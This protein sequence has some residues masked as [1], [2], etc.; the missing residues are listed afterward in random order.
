MTNFV[1]TVTYRR[2]DAGDW[3]RN[4]LI[5]HLNS[6]D[7]NTFDFWKL[8]K[9]KGFTILVVKKEVSHDIESVNE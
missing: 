4:V 6:E 9:D 7:R 1:E 5:E 3:A 8:M 2:T